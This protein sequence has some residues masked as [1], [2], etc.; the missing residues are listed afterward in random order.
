MVAMLDLELK[1]FDIKMGFLY[2]EL[3]EQIYMHQPEGFIISGKEDHVSMLKKFIYGL[4]QSP[5]QW[6]N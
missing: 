3:E 2:G 4:K 1:Q 6:Y 5:R